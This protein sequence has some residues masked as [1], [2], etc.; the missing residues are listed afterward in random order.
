MQPAKTIVAL[1]N[2]PGVGTKTV[3]NLI[4]ERAFELDSADELINF[5]QEQS[6]QLA[7]LRVPTYKEA[8]HALNLASKI[9][10]ESE[11][12]EIGI[13]SFFS[14]RYPD[15]LR[16]IDNA[17]PILYFLGNLECLSRE[18]RS[19]ALVGSREPSDW[20]GKCAFQIGKSLAELG[21]T[22]VSGLARGC[23]TLAHEGCLN[24]GGRTVAVLAGGLDEISPASNKELAVKIIEKQGC[25][26]TETP[27]GT[28]PKRHT[29]VE[30]NRIQSGVSDGV[31]IAETN[32]GSGTMTT[33]DH[34]NQQRR[35]IACIKF[36]ETSKFEGI[37][38][39]NTLLIN[40]GAAA[41]NGTEELQ[42]FVKKLSEIKHPSQPDMFSS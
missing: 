11:K 30:R 1:L 25:L 40:Q 31:I 6:S 26:I 4:E 21:I 28:R 34:A 29:F 33:A 19:V 16:N 2:L 37:A 17:P 20:G 13:L 9:I 27:I 22:V 12:L 15:R 18:Y 35:P 10:A 38:E 24:G 42:S 32:I 41:L 39:G 23:D 14:D 7:R 5:I 8:E 36:P 3:R